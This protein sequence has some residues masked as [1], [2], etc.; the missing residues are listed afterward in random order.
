[1]LGAWTR[2]ARVEMEEEKGFERWL[3]VSHNTAK[4]SLYTLPSWDLFC[5]FNHRYSFSNHVVIQV[6]NTV[7]Y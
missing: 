6:F 3:A 4:A 5:I 7:S 2:V 1:M